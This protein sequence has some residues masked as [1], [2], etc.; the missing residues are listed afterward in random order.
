MKIAITR[1]SNF[2]TNSSIDIVNDFLDEALELVEG[3]I[4]NIQVVP[5][6]GQ[7]K[8]WIFWESGE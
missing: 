2:D 7:S 4:I 8:F 5:Y 1:S 3:K 6:S